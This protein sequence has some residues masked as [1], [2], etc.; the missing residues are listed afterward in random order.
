[1]INLEK[2]VMDLMKSGDK[3]K[4]GPLST[5]GTYNQDLETQLNS[6]G[7]GNAN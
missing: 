5:G 1:M 4:R 2:T 3:F 6:K 7:D